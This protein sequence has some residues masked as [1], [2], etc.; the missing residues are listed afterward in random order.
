MTGL[1]NYYTCRAK[2]GN[3][4][5]HNS[6]NLL[7]TSLFCAETMS[8]IPEDANAECV[9]PQSDKAGKVDSCNGCPNKKDCSD[10]KNRGPNPDAEEVEERMALVKRKILVLSGKGGVGKSTVSSQ[11]AWALAD[12]QTGEDRLEVG[13]LDIDICGPSMPRMMGVEGEEVRKSNYGW[14]PVP[15]DDN[16]AVMSIGFML[17]N[18]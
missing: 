10:G 9:G 8:A 2:F 16:L 7:T 15:A 13:V 11:L 1:L 18:K 5:P 17:P 14:S 6:S 4:L 3:E 12:M